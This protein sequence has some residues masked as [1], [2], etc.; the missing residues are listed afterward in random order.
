VPAKGASLD[1]AGLGQRERPGAD[2]FS[3]TH[4]PQDGEGCA[5]GRDTRKNRQLQAGPL[6]L[7]MIAKRIVPPGAEY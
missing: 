7:R 3:F 5:V 2:D 6:S 1:G 4:M